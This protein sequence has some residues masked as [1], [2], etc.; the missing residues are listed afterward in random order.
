MLPVR[1]ASNK[2]PGVPTF[3]GTRHRKVGPAA[4]R[5]DRTL[6][7]GKS[8]AEVVLFKRTHLYIDVLRATNTRKLLVTTNGCSS[9][10]ARQCPGPPEKDTE[11]INPMSSSL[12]VR[13]WQTKVGPPWLEPLETAPGGRSVGC[14]AT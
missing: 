11:P 13:S 4:F 2:W 3:S 10:A 12:E 9:V 6:P 14:L 1:P 7:T 8:V 5:P